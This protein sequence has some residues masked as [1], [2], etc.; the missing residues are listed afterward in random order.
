MLDIN[1]LSKITEFEVQ[2]RKPYPEL[3][4]IIK[5]AN[6]MLLKNNSCLLCY[7][8]E[9]RIFKVKVYRCRQSFSSLVIAAV[10]KYVPKDIHKLL[11]T[12]NMVD[13][14]H[15]FIQFSVEDPVDDGCKI[16]GQI[17]KISLYAPKDS[18]NEKILEQRLLTI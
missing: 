16:S 15:G 1:S 9:K 3:P 12:S 8:A 13:S 7:E 2:L 10:A 4:E 18:A 6:K 17:L 14:N 5:I 11:T